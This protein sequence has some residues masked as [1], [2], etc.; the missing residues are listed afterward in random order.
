MDTPGE[1]L[2]S[3]R[4]QEG[5]RAA[6]FVLKRHF[7]Q[8]PPSPGQSIQRL[9]HLEWNYLSASWT[10]ISRH[11]LASARVAQLWV[12]GKRRRK[13]LSLDKG[14]FRTCEKGSISLHAMKPPTSCSRVEGGFTSGWEA[15][16]RQYLQVL[17]AKYSHKNLDFQLD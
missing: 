1:P 8:W 13:E 17:R 6:L 10:S 16:K 15:V 12:E 9:P 11:S 3:K 14:S 7:C 4:L 5:M 2:K